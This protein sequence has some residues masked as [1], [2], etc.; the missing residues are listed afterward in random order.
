MELNLDLG[1]ADAQL[2]SERAGILKCSEHDV[3]RLAVHLYL[4]DPALRAADL[5]D[6]AAVADYER[7]KERGELTFVSSDEAWKVLGLDDRD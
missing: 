1:D 5:Q 7:R 6:A 2:L 3:A 4:T